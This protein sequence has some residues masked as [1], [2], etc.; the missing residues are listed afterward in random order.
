[1]EKRFWSIA[2]VLLVFL[3]VGCSNA[4]KKTYEKSTVDNINETLRGIASLCA[5]ASQ[6]VKDGNIEHAIQNL[7]F[8]ESKTGELTTLYE[9]FPNVNHV[10]LSLKDRQMLAQKSQQAIAHLKLFQIQINSARSQLIQCKTSSD[11]PMKQT[12]LLNFWEDMLLANDLLKHSA[13]TFI[14]SLK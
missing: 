3:L 2:L 6:N 4:Q 9:K 11:Q 1:M 5:E 7:N 12:H 14:D 8:I 10:G 13:E